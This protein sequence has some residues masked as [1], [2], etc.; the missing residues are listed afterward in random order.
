MM[1][2]GCGVLDTILSR[3]A[4]FREKSQELRRKVMGA[5]IYPTA[6]VT[7][8]GGI[9]AVMPVAGRFARGVGSPWRAGRMWRRAVAP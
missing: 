3:L 6:V 8:A 4:D 9:L 5:L 1:R 2:V 7:I